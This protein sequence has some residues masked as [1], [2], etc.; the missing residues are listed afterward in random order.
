MEKLPS[1]LTFT[2][3][4]A[5]RR[6]QSEQ[7]QPGSFGSAASI[8]DAVISTT[9]ASNTPVIRE[10]CHNPVQPALLLLL[11]RCIGGPVLKRT[12]LQSS[13]R[14][15]PPRMFSVSDGQRRYPT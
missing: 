3:L 1:V 2:T 7:S 5:M 6:T 11:F 4:P 13:N 10:V 12:N 9:R 14:T 15:Y 8:S